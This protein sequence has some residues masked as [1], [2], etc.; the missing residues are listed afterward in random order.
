MMSPTLNAFKIV[1]K[2]GWIL[3][4]D[5]AHIQIIDHSLVRSYKENSK[6]IK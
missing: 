1:I 4:N 2:S 5:R 6:K 3:Q